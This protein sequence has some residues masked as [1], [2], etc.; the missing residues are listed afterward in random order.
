MQRG[1]QGLQAECKMVRE[2]S[3]AHGCS[4]CSQDPDPVTGHSADHESSTH[5][6]GL[7]AHVCVNANEHSG[8]KAKY[9]FKNTPTV[10][11]RATT[12]PSP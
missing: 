6:E 3:V 9:F 7:C 11:I 5:N 2:Q 12:P 1:C 4:S 10:S 8:A